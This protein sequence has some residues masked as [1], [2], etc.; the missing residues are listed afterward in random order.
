[1]NVL[2][3]V[4]RGGKGWLRGRWTSTNVKSGGE[5]ECEEEKEDNLIK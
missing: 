4:K 5:G 2:G 3:G 1:M